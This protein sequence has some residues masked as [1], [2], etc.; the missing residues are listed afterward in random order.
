MIATSE[1]EPGPRGAFYGGA[2]LVEPVANALVKTLML[3]N[4][5][6]QSCNARRAF[7]L[8]QSVG[9]IGFATG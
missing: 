9:W 6:P 4:A 7:V 8:A 5:Q 3:R 1:H 2:S